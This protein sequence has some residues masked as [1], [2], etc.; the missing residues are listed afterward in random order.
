MLVYT[1]PNRR[2]Y[3]RSPINTSSIHNH[4]RRYLIWLF[5]IARTHNF[6]NW[7]PTRVP[8]RDDDSI[9]IL[10]SYVQTTKYTI[11]PILSFPR[12]VCSYGSRWEWLLQNP[13]PA[14]RAH[15]SF[16]S[17]TASV[18]SFARCSSSVTTLSV[19]SP[20]CSCCCNSTTSFSF[21]SVLSFNK[22]R[23]FAI[24]LCTAFFN[25]PLGTVYT[26]R[27]TKCTTAQ[28]KQQ[29]TAAHSAAVTPAISPT[30]RRRCAGKMAWRD[31]VD[32][33]NNSDKKVEKSR[34]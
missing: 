4:K 10:L 18:G 8:L 6:T 28:G 5:P 3:N 27:T 30:R 7:I 24:L 15:I 22:P 33:M 17:A 14:N 34:N 23:R 31:I 32:W 16:S 19:S 20:L 2:S 12:F 26:A 11:D 25:S 1:F 29:H 13:V 21:L 9:F